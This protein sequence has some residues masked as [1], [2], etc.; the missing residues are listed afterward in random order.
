VYTEDFSN[1]PKF[2]NEYFEKI[3]KKDQSI[4]ARLEAKGYKV[5]RLWEHEVYKEPEKCLD[6]IQ[7]LL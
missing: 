1:Q 3:I 4:K 6:R 7:A 5:L 2:N